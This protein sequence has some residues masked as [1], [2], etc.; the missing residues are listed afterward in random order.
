MGLDRELDL[1]QAP[2][3]MARHVARQADVIIGRVD[4]DRTDAGRRT[5]ASPVWGSF[6]DKRILA[7]R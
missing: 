7:L 2:L 3:G 1:L 6:S 5:P 4:L